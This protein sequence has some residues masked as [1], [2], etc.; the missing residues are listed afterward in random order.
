MTNSSEINCVQQT[1]M[2]FMGNIQLPRRKRWYTWCSEHIFCGRHLCTFYK[3]FSFV[4]LFI[5]ICSKNPRFIKCLVGQWEGKNFSRCLVNIHGLLGCSHGS[6][7]PAEVV[8]VFMPMWHTCLI[9]NMKIN[10]TC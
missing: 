6:C 8:C 3:L 2:M 1:L 4:Y 7:S 10:Q 5:I 9:T